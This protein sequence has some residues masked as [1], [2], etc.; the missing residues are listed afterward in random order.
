LT[1][2]TYGIGHGGFEAMYL[3]TLG[4]IQS[5]AYASLIK[6]GQFEN[7]L[8]LVSQT[9]PEQYEVLKAVPEQLAETSIG[10]VILSFIERI[11]AILIHIACSIL[12]FM[13]VKGS[14]QKWL[15]PLAILLHASIDIP[16]G[17]YQRGI[18]TNTYVIEFGLLT[19]ALTLFGIIYRYLYKPI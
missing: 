1:A 2:I 17:L 6:S 8:D 10:E 11:S 14:G 7:V 9:A 12:V 4:G 13:A 5:L 19:F 3:L 16:A 18:I 15:F